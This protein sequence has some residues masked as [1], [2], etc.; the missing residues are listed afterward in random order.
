MEER[1]RQ[2][3]CRRRRRQEKIV[4]AMKERVDKMK[5]KSKLMTWNVQKASIDFPRGCRFVEILR[6][7]QKTVKMHSFLNL[8]AGSRAY[9]G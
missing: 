4:K 8:Q 9:C 1:K 7:V 6:Y 3:V 5:G 2:R